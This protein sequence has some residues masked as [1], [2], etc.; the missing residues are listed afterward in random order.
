MKRK[1]KV[2]LVRDTC[3]CGETTKTKNFCGET[4]AASKEK[5]E[6][7]VRFRLYG[8]KYAYDCFDLQGDDYASEYFEAVEA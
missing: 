5:A 4:Y 7:N 1:Y 8:N 3:C 2:Y 6:S